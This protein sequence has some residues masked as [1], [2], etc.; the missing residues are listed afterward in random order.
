M[1]SV[2]ME[3]ERL[4]ASLNESQRKIM[5][6]VHALIGNMGGQLQ[7]VSVIY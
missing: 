4:V 3:A 2:I 6:N 1:G 5:E 7:H